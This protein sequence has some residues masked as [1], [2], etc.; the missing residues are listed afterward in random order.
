[1]VLL[2]ILL[3]CS[4]G[5]A[6]TRKKRKTGDF[7]IFLFCFDGVRV[8]RFVRLRGKYLSLTMFCRGE[9]WVW[10]GG[11]EPTLPY[12]A[13][14]S[15]MV[16]NTM[17]KIPFFLT[18][19]PPSSPLPPFPSPTPTPPPSLLPFPISLFSYTREC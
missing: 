2:N 19:P 12:A 3:N 16:T 6:W 1:M 18:H 4:I 7:L 5:L 14:C 13:L 15:H 17:K 10:G 11:Q 9:G 8:G